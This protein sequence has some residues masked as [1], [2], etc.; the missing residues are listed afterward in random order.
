MKHLKVLAVIICITVLTVFTWFRIVKEDSADTSTIE[1]LIY[2]SNLPP[3]TKMYFSILHFSQ[4]YDVPSEFAFAIAY[5]ETG[6]RGPFHWN[7]NPAQTSYANAMGPMQILPSTA[8]WIAKSSIS[9]DDL[10]HNIPLN[11]ELS[12]KY[13]S[14][15]KKR[16]GDWKIVFGYYN[17]GYPIVNNYAIRVYNATYKWDKVSD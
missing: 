6:Y 3:S 4:K 11:V 14:Y 13:V 2:N 1:E 9:H 12:M 15:L 5:A 8:N 16:Y 7:Y 10:K 17:T